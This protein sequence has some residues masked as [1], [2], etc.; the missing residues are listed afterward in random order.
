MIR[1]HA[2]WMRLIDERILELLKAEDQALRSRA[3][4]DRLGELSPHLE[5]PKQYIDARLDRLLYYR[6][7][8]TDGESWKYCLSEHGFSYL[9][10]ALDANDLPASVEQQPEKPT[11]KIDRID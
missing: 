9:N 4:Q 1:R 7:V 10:G 5:Y 6:L 2:E 8:E 11:V 3:I